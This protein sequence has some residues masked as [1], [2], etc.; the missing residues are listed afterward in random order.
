VMLAVFML[1]GAFMEATPN[2]VIFGPLLLPLALE[3]GM[4]DV[5]FSI[6]MLTTLGLGFITPP[7]GLNL[8]VLSAIT[9]ASSTSISYRAIPFMVSMLLVAIIIAAFPQLSMIFL[10]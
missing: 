6:F 8:F 10:E 2:I 4:N 7:L 1:A 9:G 3:I 5:H